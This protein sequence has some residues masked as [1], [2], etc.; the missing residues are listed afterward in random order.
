MNYL[1]QITNIINNKIYIGVHKT[2]NPDDGYMGSGK[3]IKSAIKKYGIEN[4]KKEIL[5]T[6]DTYQQA[7]DK[8]AKVV[9]DEFLLREDVYNLRRGG[10]GGFDYINKNALA[11]Q[12]LKNKEIRIKT[13]ES[14]LLHSQTDPAFAEKLSC[15]AKKNLYISHSTGLHKSFTGRKHT[16]DTKNKMSGHR[17]QSCGEKNSQYGTCWIYSLEQN[18]NM[19]INRDLLDIYLSAGWTKGRKIKITSL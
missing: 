13:G 8:E 7:L 12:N 14:R 15:V 6:F 19:K 16:V 3:V 4:F 10:T 11:V 9:T 5:E 1:Y 2:H 18:I 17:Q